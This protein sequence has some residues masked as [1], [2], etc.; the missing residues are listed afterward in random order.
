M[1]K[2]EG[3]PRQRKKRRASS[4]HLE[5][6]FSPVDG[7]LWTCTASY[8][9]RRGH[10][11]RCGGRNTGDRPS[12]HFPRSNEVYSGRHRA[13]RDHS[14]SGDVAHLNARLIAIR[15]WRVKWIE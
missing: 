3:L 11:V 7:R 15:V 8:R 1:R 13:S 14:Q 6:A 12:V 5:V 10:P 9:L 2:T 4:L